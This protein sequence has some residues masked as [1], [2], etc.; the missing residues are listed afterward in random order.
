[1]DPHQENKLL[2]AFGQVTIERLM[3]REAAPIPGVGVL[4]VHHETSRL[5]EPSEGQRQLLPPRDRL[6]FEP[7]PSAT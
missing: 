7:N 2:R 6:V 3:R 1:M 4:R 5:T